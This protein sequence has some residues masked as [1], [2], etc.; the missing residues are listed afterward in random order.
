MG[1][2]CRPTPSIRLDNIF[3][4]KNKTKKPYLFFLLPLQLAGHALL[5]SVLELGIARDDAF[6]LFL[7]A[8]D[9]LAQ[10]LCGVGKLINVF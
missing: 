6:H 3:P 8:L 2:C 9:A 4:A 1:P 5:A 7:D 10:P